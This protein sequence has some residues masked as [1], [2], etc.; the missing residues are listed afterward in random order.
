MWGYSPLV[1]GSLCGLAG[2]ANNLPTSRCE[3]CILPAISEEVFSNS[4]L[5]PD[6]NCIRLSKDSSRA[7]SAPVPTP[8]YNAT[9]K[10]ESSVTPYLK[11]LHGTSSSCGSYKE[12][13]I[14]GRI[15][16]QQRGFSSSISGGGFGHFEWAATSAVL[17]QG[18]GA[19]G[20]RLLSPGYSDFQLFKATLQFLASRD[21]VTNPLFFQA[22]EFSTQK[23]DTPTFYDGPRGM[24][25]LFKM[26]SWSYRLVRYM[27]KPYLC[28][29][30]LTS[31]ATARGKNFAGHVPGCHYRQL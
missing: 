28:I 21:L 12:A 24:N 4:K 18:G 25:I 7:G 20:Q 16:L 2:G 14:L 22:E 3:I 31:E 19:H 5:L 29:K 23:L 17:L 15:W 9:L 30:T 13:C 27:I 10:S 6:K 8:F 11:L 26:T 1:A